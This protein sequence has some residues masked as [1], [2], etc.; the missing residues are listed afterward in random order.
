MLFLDGEGDKK[1]VIGSLQ[2]LFVE[3]QLILSNPV[4]SIDNFKDLLAVGTEDGTVYLVQ[5]ESIHSQ[6]KLPS[7]V[8]STR[9]NNEYLVC[10]T[11]DTLYII[12]YQ[13]SEIHP[14]KLDHLKGENTIIWDMLIHNDKVYTG[15]SMGSV[16]IWDLKSKT[17][18][19]KIQAHQADILTLVMHENRLYSGGV[20]TKT[21]EYSLFNG[22]Y[23]ITGSKHLHSH[24]ITSMVAFPKPFDCLVSG[25]IDTSFTLAAPLSLEFAKTKIEKRWLPNINPL[26]YC[27][28]L[29]LLVCHFDEEL[30]VWQLDPLVSHEGVSLF[31]GQRLAHGAQQQLLKIAVKGQGNIQSSC[32]SPQG[33]QIACSD[34]KS[35]RIFNVSIA[36][37]VKV[38]NAGKYEDGA[39]QM[40]FSKNVLYYCSINGEL[41]C[42]ESGETRV[43][44]KIHTGYVNVMAQCDSFIATA[45]SNRTVVLYDIETG[46][47]RKLARAV[48]TG[49]EIHTKS[50]LLVVVTERNNVL[51]YNL[52]DGSEINMFEL[53][54]DRII[55]HARLWR[56]LLVN[57]GKTLILWS[58]IAVVAVDLDFSNDYSEEKEKVRFHKDFQGTMGMFTDGDEMI[59]VNRPLGQLL[60]DLPHSFKSKVYGQ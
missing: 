30:R 52:Q 36:Q 28:A 14:I 33:D 41:K 57:Q 32:I 34:S 47:S 24:D 42:I 17:L 53:K 2:G 21:I 8:I 4:W 7:R 35:I 59:V 16:Q 51:L 44:H 15:D 54:M 45:C 40:F 43:L 9:I 3:N 23:E 29:K 46:K 37:G 55:N 22:R 27:A 58:D 13:T 12:A 11:L 18:V 10:S 38:S 20:D 49:I 48:C 1:L 6:F 31:E 26:S 25:S 56:P 60:G 39:T 19:Q 50:N 5:D